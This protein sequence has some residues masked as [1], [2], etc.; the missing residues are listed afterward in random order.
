MEDI[1]AHP[2][3]TPPDNSD[4]DIQVIEVP[5]EDIEAELGMLYVDAF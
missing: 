2:Q 1:E 5:E 4:S 3:N